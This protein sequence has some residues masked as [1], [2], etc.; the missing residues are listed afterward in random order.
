MERLTDPK[1]IYKV[2]LIE[3]PT[4]EFYVFYNGTRKQQAEKILKLSDAYLE[5]NGK[6]RCPKR[7]RVPELFTELFMEATH[8]I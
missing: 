2:N 4:S 7:Q 1:D 5:K 6:T 3:I 8:P